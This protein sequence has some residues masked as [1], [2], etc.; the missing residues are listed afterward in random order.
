MVKCPACGGSVALSAIKDHAAS[1]P[2]KSGAAPAKAPAKAEPSI[3]RSHDT[4]Y[5]SLEQ[6]P[7]TAP[8]KK[9]KKQPAAAAVAPE[10]P[11][12]MADP[13]A[14]AAEQAVTPPPNTPLCYSLIN[15]YVF[16]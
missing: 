3:A 5:D 11:V 6:A 16:I 8:V 4:F 14:V 7:T 15:S 2:G 12:V 1:C 9:E 13:V 10:F